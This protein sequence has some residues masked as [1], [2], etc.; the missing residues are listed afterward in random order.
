MRRCVRLLAYMI[1]CNGTQE[2]PEEQELKLVNDAA[3]PT[4]DEDEGA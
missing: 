3:V 2:K 1:I 4:D